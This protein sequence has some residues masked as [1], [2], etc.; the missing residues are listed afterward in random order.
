[1]TALPKSDAQLDAEAEA[2]DAY[3]PIAWR[4]D[5]MDRLADLQHDYRRESEIEQLTVTRPPVTRHVMDGNVVLTVQEPADA[6]GRNLSAPMIALIGAHQADE[7]RYDRG[8]HPVRAAL[9]AWERVCRREHRQV[10]GR[11]PMWPDH[12]HGP[13][14]A[15]LAWAIVR[16]EMSLNAAAL[17]FGC[18]YPRAE[19]LLDRATRYMRSSIDRWQDERDAH[20]QSGHDRDGCAL[21]R[22]TA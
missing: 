1:M 17:F 21:C 4:I 19:R 20:D 10:P 8:R 14:C 13:L 5:L 2:R 11:A 16:D 22:A 12:V 18:E 3:D 7:A 6:V 9:V 15:D